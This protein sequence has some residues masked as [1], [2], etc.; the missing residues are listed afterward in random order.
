[1]II[2]V[3]SGKGGTGKTTVS[4]NLARVAE[5][6]QLLDC[7]V[8]EPNA[9]LFIK[10]VIEKKSE[11]SIPVP[12]ID[13]SKCT[14]CG[15]CK[16]VCAYN[17]LTIIAGKVLF[18]PELCHGCGACSYFCP[19]SA[20]KEKDKVIGVLEEGTKDGLVF[21]HGLLKIG[22][23]MG[24]PLIRA[25]KKT[26]KADRTVII[27]A[28]P[29]TAC[30]MISA[31]SATDVCVLVTEPTPFGLNDLRLAVNV[32][33][34]IGIPFGVVINR[35]G[36]GYSAVDDYCQEENIPV[37]AKIPF[38]K[39]TA[40]IYSGGKLLVDASDEYR[41]MFSALLKNVYELKG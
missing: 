14:A 32:V 25:V 36:L 37:L 15:K 22:E 5:N 34:E 10:P 1:M 9:H 24:P 11:I 29:G 40:E 19:A 23:P 16:E 33:R 39:R 35:Y 8:E 20:I 18:F 3:A 21:G 13:E 41:E 6:A 2:S 26:I 7:D 31:V 30:S 28:P 4:S 27:D 12:D 38:N 17:A